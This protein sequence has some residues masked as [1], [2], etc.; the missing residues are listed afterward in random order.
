MLVTAG[1]E[2]RLHDGIRAHA[3]GL[4]PQG[5]RPKQV[6]MCALTRAGTKR[7]ARELRR[8]FGADFITTRTNG[9]TEHGVNRLGPRESG[10]TRFENPRRQPAPPGVQESDSPGIGQ[11]DRHAIRCPHGE[12]QVGRA[13]ARAVAGGDRSRLGHVH[14]SVPVHL[15]QPHRGAVSKDGLPGSR[16]TYKAELAHA[17]PG[18]LQVK[19]GPVRRLSP[20]PAHDGRA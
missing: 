19:N 9:R 7:V 11:K 2:R 5:R 1:T 8:H 6:E 3:A 16:A 18:G 13:R 10:E 20:S 12:K 14:D 17:R 15:T 4:E